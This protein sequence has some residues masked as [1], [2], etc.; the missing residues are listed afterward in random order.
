MTPVMELRR[1]HKHAGSRDDYQLITVRPEQT[2]RGRQVQVQGP[3]EKPCGLGVKFRKLLGCICAEAEETSVKGRRCGPRSEGGITEL[4]IFV[5]KA[6]LTFARS[7]PHAKQIPLGAGPGRVLGRKDARTCAS[8]LL[9]YKLQGLGCSSGP[10]SWLWN[11]SWLLRSEHSSPW[12]A[13]LVGLPVQ[14]SKL[15][16]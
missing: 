2:Q 1:R 16:G 15:F 6:E 7:D 3:D 9:S 12:R 4:W 13:L 11:W 5:C 8:Q 14:S 10:V